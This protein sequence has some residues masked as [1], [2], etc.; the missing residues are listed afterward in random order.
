MVNDSHC[1]AVL[2][3]LAMVTLSSATKAFIKLRFMNAFI[4]LRSYLLII[5]QNEIDYISTS[6]RWRSL[7]Q[8]VRIYRGA[9]CGIDHFGHSENAF[10]V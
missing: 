4:K 3:I 9:D 10:E 6:N 5:T 2:I 7:L 8:E 1:F